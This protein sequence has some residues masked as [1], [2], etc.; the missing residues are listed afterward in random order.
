MH[1]QF[2]TFIWQRVRCLK[3]WQA[4]R[5]DILQNTLHHNFVAQWFFLHLIPHMIMICV[6]P[7]STNLLTSAQTHKPN[8]TSSPFELQTRQHAT[9]VCKK[10]E[11]YI[12]QISFLWSCHW[13]LIANLLWI[14]CLHA[15][16]SACIDFITRNNYKHLEHFITRENNFTKSTWGCGMNI[17]RDKCDDIYQLRHIMTLS[18]LR[19]CVVSKP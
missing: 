18:Y 2:T 16:H 13:I 15:H 7:T 8:T 11:I 12:L 3:R 1:Q 5:H 14:S 4:S 19:P 10:R 9:F 6:C 17:A